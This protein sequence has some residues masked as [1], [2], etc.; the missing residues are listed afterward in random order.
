MGVLDFIKS[1]IKKILAQFS[2]KVFF[3][4]TMEKLFIML[5]RGEH[6]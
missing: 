5:I 1:G 3:S 4:P 6:Q 2:E